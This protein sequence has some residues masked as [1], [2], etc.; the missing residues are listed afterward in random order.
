MPAVAA[1]EEVS[2]QRGKQ[3]DPEAATAFLEIREKILQQMQA[4]TK[5]L[6]VLQ[7]LWKVAN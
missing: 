7:A 5:R 6:G 4:E 1:F 2:K 3:F